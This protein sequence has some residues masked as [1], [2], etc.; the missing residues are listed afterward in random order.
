MW[1]KLN[2]M[3]GLAIMIIFLISIIVI[4][5]DKKHFMNDYSISYGRIIYVNAP[6]WKS[7]GDYGVVY[8]YLVNN[9]KYHGD[10]NFIFCDRYQTIAKMK[11]LLLNKQFPIA[12]SVKERDISL[13]LIT[14]ET[15]KKFNYIIPDSLLIYDS[16]LTCK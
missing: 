8:E 14:K 7:S 3:I 11:T 9:Q 2:K 4:L 13:I 6:S 5:Y 1:K 10:N 15:A 16:I 12:Y